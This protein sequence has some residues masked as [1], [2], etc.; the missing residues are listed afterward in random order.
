MRA[1]SYLP[2]RKELKTK[3]GCVN[4]K[5][6]G[7][8]CFLWSILASL[9]PVQCRNHPDR[10]S[11]Y[12]EHED[13]LN[14]SGIQY[15]VD[16]KDINKFKYQNNTSVNVYGYKDKNDHCNASRKFIIYHCW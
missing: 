2:L 3:R 10:V 12:Q 11:K 9:H 13:E 7:E 15:P 16:I 14:M 8:K 6:N 4:I 1:S 5:S